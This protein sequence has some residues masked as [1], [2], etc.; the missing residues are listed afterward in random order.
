MANVPID[1]ELIEWADTIYVMESAHRNRISKKFKKYLSG[2]RI[3]VL[4]I[5]DDYEF[6]QPSLV[7]I[8]ER[9]VSPLLARYV[10]R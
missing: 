3:V 7:A 4:N 10:Q 9:K 2:K 5:P 6:M 1:P 8:L